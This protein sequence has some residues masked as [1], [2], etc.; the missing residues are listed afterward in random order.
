MTV[1]GTPHPRYP[2]WRAQNNAIHNSSY[3]VISSFVDAIASPFVFPRCTFG[4]PTPMQGAPA[5]VL[6]IAVKLLQYIKSVLRR[7]AYLQKKKKKADKNGPGTEMP[8]V[9]LHSHRPSVTD[10]CGRNVPLLRGRVMI[11]QTAG[12]CKV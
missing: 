10:S 11:G 3:P 8:C 2:R 6:Y 1:A 7:H 5:K 12:V 4:S 9:S